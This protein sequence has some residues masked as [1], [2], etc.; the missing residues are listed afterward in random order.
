GADPGIVTAMETQATCLDLA[1][2]AKDAGPDPRSRIS[3]MAAGLVGSEILRIAGEIR[4]LVAG[5]RAGCHLTVGDFDPR[6]SPTPAEL[7]DGVV[8]ALQRGETNY[9]PS[10]GIPELRA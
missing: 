2:L 4:A 9:P 1:A 8:D 6:Y 5:G 7:A 10:N 3:S